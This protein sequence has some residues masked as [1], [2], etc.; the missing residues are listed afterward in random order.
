VQVGA[1]YAACS[2]GWQHNLALKADGTL[3]AWGTDIYGQLGTGSLGY[4]ARPGV[5]P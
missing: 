2:A 4:R 1:G 5:V 3:W